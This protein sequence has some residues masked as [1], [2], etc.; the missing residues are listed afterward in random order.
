MKKQPLV[1]IVIPTYKRPN[2]L[3]NAITS[4]TN[5]KYTNWEIIIVDDNG[6]NEYRIK[7]KKNIDNIVKKFK[8]NKKLKY[9]EQKT[10]QGACKARN[11]GINNS[12]GDWV[13]FLDDD[14]E[15]TIDKLSKQIELLN[16]KDLGFVYCNIFQK[17]ITKKREK[18]IKN[19]IREQTFKKLL[20][21]G[22]GICT[23]AFLIKKEI[24]LKIGGFDETLPSYQDYDLLLKLSNV[25]KCDFVNETLMY[26][27]LD[28]DGI[29]KNYKAKLNGLEKI[30]ER[31]SKYYYEL[32]IKKSLYRYYYDAGKYS[33]MCGNYKK[34]IKYF[35]KSINLNP[36][37]IKQY[38]FFIFFLF[39]I[40][41]L[42]DF[43]KAKINYNKRGEW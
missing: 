34:G 22:V 18:L 2:K 20:E 12:D 16:E 33:F 21:K 29:S 26:Y 14:D 25:A 30:I 32:D 3:K 19:D 6:D 37:F 17:D 39:K 7:T 1:S 41:K 10:N 13:S 15:W 9:I 31:Y 24:L 4:I 40:N 27:I 43:I 28:T 11:V 38:L 36:M 5:Q 42:N 8:L 23:S 35:L